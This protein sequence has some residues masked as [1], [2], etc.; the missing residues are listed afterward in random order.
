MNIAITPTAET[1]IQQLIELGHDT[2][3]EIVEQALKY[4]YSQQLID[5]SYGFPELT[6]SELV[7]E[8][9]QRWQRFQQNRDGVCQSEV[10]AR[11]FNKT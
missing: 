8:N 7:Q 4:F 3:E 11:F 6:E 9:E 10:E 1:L 2:P 5:T